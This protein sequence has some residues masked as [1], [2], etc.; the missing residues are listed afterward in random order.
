LDNFDLRSTSCIIRTVDLWG[1]TFNLTQ[2]VLGK[3]LDNAPESTRQLWKFLLKTSKVR[4]NGGLWD[5]DLPPIR[6]MSIGSILFAMIIGVLPISWV[7]CEIT[8]AGRGVVGT[9]LSSLKSNFYWCFNLLSS[10]RVMFALVFFISS[11]M[12]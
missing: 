10:W 5:L 3:M 4:I 2:T 11:T 7:A 1:W 12:L 8:V 9:A 6:A